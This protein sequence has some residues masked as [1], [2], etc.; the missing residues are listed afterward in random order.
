MLKSQRFTFHRSVFIDIS[1]HICYTESKVR[2]GSLDLWTFGGKTNEKSIYFGA[3]VF[4]F[5]PFFVR[6]CTVD[7]H[8]KPI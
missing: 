7:R 8:G 6:C 2:I 5:L 4:D 1:Q 3:G